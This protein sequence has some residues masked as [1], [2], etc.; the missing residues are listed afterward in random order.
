LYV[1][2]I[3][4]PDPKW[5]EIL[6]ASGGQ[7]ASLAVACGVFLLVAHLGWIPEPYPWMVQAAVFVLIL[8]GMLAITSFITAFPK[9]NS[10]A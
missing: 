7:S 8:S 3:M 1:P 5:L 4:T 6:K 9:I 10:A 2:E